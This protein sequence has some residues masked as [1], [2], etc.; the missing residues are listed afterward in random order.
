MQN[1]QC[2]TCHAE[3]EHRNGKFGGFWY[4]KQHGTISDI[5]AAI[6]RSTQRI[7]EVS[8]QRGGSYTSDPLLDAVKR[9]GYQLGHPTDEL[10]QLVD[11]INDPDPND[12]EEED[13]HW[14]NIRPY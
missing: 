5:G 4:C 6:L 7:S 10:G 12:V 9:K 1:F 2:P 14:M 8:V 13:D 11:W 3:M